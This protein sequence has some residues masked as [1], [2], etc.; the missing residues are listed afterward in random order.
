MK[1][2][3]LKNNKEKVIKIKDLPTHEKP[4]EK[5]LEKGPDILSMSEL[6]A[7]IL[8]TG[9]KKENIINMSSRLLKEY[10]NKAISEQ[11][12][13]QILSKQFDLPIVK[14]SQLI[15]CFELGKRLFKENQGIM[16]TIK[17]AKDVYNY[18]QDMKS[19]NK[20]QFR[21][22]YLNS[23]A[24]IIHDEIISLGTL[25]CSIVHPREVFQPA[26]EYSA[27][28]I[29]LAHNHPSG[30]TSPSLEDIKVSANLIKA[31]NILGIEVLDHIIITKNSYQS[32]N[33]NIN[34][35]DNY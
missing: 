19:L 17:N 35:E 14:S 30:D 29:V 33:L 8:Q 11:T 16:K 26:I 27:T 28:A 31:G 6:I 7:I 3:C 15:A 22:L 1:K 23:R 2:Y 13:P 32:I 20:E 9:T 4:R 5:L 10:G 25:D 34:N 24:K 18:L 21:G 12:D